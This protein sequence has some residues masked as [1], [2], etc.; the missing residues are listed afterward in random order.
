MG[1]IF[2]HAQFSMA[3]YVKRYDWCAGDLPLDLGILQKS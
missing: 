2:F 3:N 1:K